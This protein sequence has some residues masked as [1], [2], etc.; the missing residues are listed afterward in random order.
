METLASLGREVGCLLL[1][2]VAECVR[3]TVLICK[4][5]QAN[6]EKL[7]PQ[8]GERQQHSVS[9]MMEHKTWE[10]QGE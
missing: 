4:V 5:G 7:E 1:L 8:T 2:E 10:P 9:K 3:E 6:E